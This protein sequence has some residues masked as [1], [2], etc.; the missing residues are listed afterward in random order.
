MYVK[1]DDATGKLLLLVFIPRVG[2][3]ET[4]EGCSCIV[5]VNFP[6]RRIRGPSLLFVG[7]IRT[8]NLRFH[9]EYSRSWCSRQMCTWFRN[10]QRQGNPVGRQNL[11]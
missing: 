5:Y 4:Y 11:T 9:P 3:P 6:A 8:E 2:F 1:E 10:P 7:S